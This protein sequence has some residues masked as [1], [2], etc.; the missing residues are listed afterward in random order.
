MA[1]IGGLQ[2]KYL[3]ALPATA[4]LVII[5][6]GVVG[7]A[8]AFFA[9]RAGLH[10][11]LLER[12]P[13]LCTLTTPASTGAFRLQFDNEEELRMVRRS[14]ELFLNFNEITGQRE[15]DLDIRRQGY[16]FLTTTAEGAERQRRVVSRQHG[17]GQTDIELLAGDEVRHRFPFVSENVRQGRFRQDDGF[18]DPKALTMGL[19][20]AS[21]ASVL[22]GCAVTGFGIE[23]GRLCGVE[24]ERG[25]VDTNTAVIA[26]GPFSG[27]VA[28]RAGVDLPVQT[29]RRQKVIIPDAPEVPAQA[30]MTIDDDTAT[31]WRPVLQGAYLLFTDPATPPSPPAEDVTP[32]HR[33]AFDLLDPASPRAVARVSPFWKNV[34]ERG[35]TNWI[36]QAGQYTMTPDHRPLI[37]QTSIKGL[38]ANTGYSG[39]GIMG[40]PA[41]SQLLVEVV[42]GQLPDDRNPFRLDRT[43]AERELDIL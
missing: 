28:A 29:V 6:G 33:F 8:T 24:T 16:L 17:W 41:G 22:T 30:P 15:Y 9:A 3:A 19:A 10:P 40:S 13:R 2:V 25:S 38:Y 37:G 12:R 42:T 35:S 36:V 7:A 5:G 1:T 39:H 31:H 43:F 4:D 23:G 26:A 18:L 34:W 27:L 11:L 20:S 14:V 32:D 21:G